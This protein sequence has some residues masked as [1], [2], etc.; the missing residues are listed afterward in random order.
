[1]EKETTQITKTILKEFI[2]SGETATAQNFDE[3]MHIEISFS[4]G[5]LNKYIMF[6][7]AKF[8]S[9]NTFE[10]MYRRLLKLCEQYKC[11]IS[12]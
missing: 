9:F 5:K 4:A 7:N 3:S 12:I 6:V 2:K 1:M 8:E 11:S 10:G